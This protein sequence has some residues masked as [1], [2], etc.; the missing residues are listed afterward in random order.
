[1]FWSG[2]SL[3]Q[4]L[5]TNSSNSV[6]DAMRLARTSDG[7]KNVC[8]PHFVLLVTACGRFLTM[9]FGCIKNH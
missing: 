4:S 6:P 8:F 3:S 1:M 9:D 5:G 2:G 7:F